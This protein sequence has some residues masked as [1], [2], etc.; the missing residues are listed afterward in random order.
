MRSW[1]PDASGLDAACLGP[2]GRDLAVQGQQRRHEGLAVAEREGLPDQRALAPRS[3][4]ST[5]PVPSHRG[6]STMKTDSPR[7]ADEMSGSVQASSMTASAR[8]ANMH[9]VFTPFTSHPPSVRAAEVVSAVASM[10]WFGHRDGHHDLAAGDSREPL[11]LLPWV[12][13][14]RG[15]GSGSQ[16]A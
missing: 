11:A 12:C 9:H 13:P 6:F 1:C 10:V 2:G 16:D 4:V 3:W 7:Y 15:L 5:K 14:G 8:A